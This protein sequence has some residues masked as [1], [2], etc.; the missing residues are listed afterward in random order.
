MKLQQLTTFFWTANLGS[1]GAAA[2]H[3]HAT[4]STVSMRI[5]ELERSLGVE[6]FDRSHR[7]IKLTAKGR[8]LFGYAG[9]LLGLVAEIEQRLTAS[10]CLSGQVRIGVAEVISITW[11]P[12]FIDVISQRYPGVRLEIDEGLTGDLMDN[13][14]DGSLDLILVPGKTPT[15][16]MLSLSLGHMPFAWMASPS[17]ALGEHVYS[18][19]ALSRWPIIGLKSS[20]YH[21]A[22]VEGWFRQDHA[23]C[24]YLARCKSMTVAASMAIQ[25]LGVTYLPVRCYEAQMTT[26]ALQ[27]I[28]TDVVFPP[29]EFIAA[30]SI[31]DVNPLPLALAKIAEEISD[32]DTVG[33]RIRGVSVPEPL[34]D[35]SVRGKAC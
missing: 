21:T 19:R 8:E 3:L 29:V 12:R 33:G 15:P 13:L 31:D 1:F 22:V 30:T 17:L 28:R 18:A 14:A 16:G 26:G 5:K 20:S 25:G 11:L 6:L 32:F 27:V 7:K 2:E 34:H 35:A 10:D 24:K 9:S 4:Q 23:A